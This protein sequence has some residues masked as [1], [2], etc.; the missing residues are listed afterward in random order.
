M[1]DGVLVMHNGVLGVHDGVLVVHDGVLVILRKLM[2]Q[3]CFLKF[4]YWVPSLLPSLGSLP[5]FL[6]CWY[7]VLFH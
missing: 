7:I 4:F 2:F 5:P 1:H 6:I 3:C